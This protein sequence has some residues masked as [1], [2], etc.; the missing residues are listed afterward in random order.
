MKKTGLFA[1]AL[2]ILLYSCSGSKTEDHSMHEDHE[3]EGSEMHDG[4]DMGSSDSEHS[5]MMKAEGT[6][7]IIDTYLAVKNALVSDD[8]KAAAA[9]SGEL[10][11]AL[12]AFDL[13]SSKGEDI[14]EL[15]RLQMEAAMVAE[16]LSADDIAAQRESFQALSVLMK[17]FIKI[18]GTDRT[19]YQQYCPMYKNNTGGIWLSASEDIKN[20]LFGSSMLT[21]GRVEETL[22]LN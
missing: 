22:A 16:N 14:E 18:A 7:A 17:D 12:K 11:N 6:T 15:E 13:N 2:G 4:H 9:Q 5:T 8:S 19:L 3:M 1:L 20:P 21:C 10:V